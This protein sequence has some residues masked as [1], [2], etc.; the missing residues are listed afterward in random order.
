M[1]SACSAE[2]AIG[3]PKPS[4]IALRHAASRRGLR[5]CWRPGS[6][7]C[8]SG[9]APAA[10]IS[11]PAVTPARAS[12]T[13][14]Q[15]SASAMAVRVCA[16]MRWARLPRRGVLEARGVDQ[17]Q[18]Q[19]ARAPHRPRGGRGSRP[20]CHARWRACAPGQP[21]EQRRLADIG[22]ADDGEGEGHGTC[23]ARALPQRHKLGVVGVEIERAVGDH[24][25]DG[26]ARRESPP[27]PAA[28]RYRARS[29]RR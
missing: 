19:I 21:V 18:G 8:R 26:G 22:P 7:A 24:R 3:S 23:S 15:T 25:R 4:A 14:R 5:I 13:N 27:G 1:P 29:P 20:A 6:P 11:S 9:A 16:V 10:M 12:I 2:I 28:C 17:A